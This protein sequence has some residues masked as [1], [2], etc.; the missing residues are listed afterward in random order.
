M[1]KAKSF[2]FNTMR[3]FL[4]ATA[5]VFDFSSPTAA[6]LAN[7]TDFYQALQDGGYQ[8]PPDAF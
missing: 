4:A 6:E 5:G 8:A 2:G 3:V 1:Q 7:L